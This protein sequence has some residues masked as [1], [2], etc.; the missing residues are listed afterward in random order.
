ME[1]VAHFSMLLVSFFVRQVLIDSVLEQ[2]L[3]WAPP[4]FV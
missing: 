2:V 4:F 3:T 1:K